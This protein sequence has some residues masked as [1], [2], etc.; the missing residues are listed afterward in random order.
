MFWGIL[1]VYLA[2]A[3]ATARTLMPWC[4]E[5]WFSGPAL[6]LLRWSTMGT[7]VLDAT[8]TWHGRNL[9]GIGQYTYWITPLYP[10]S[11]FLWFHVMPFGLFTVRLYSVLWGLV[12][13][14]AWWAL[15]RK[16]SG[17][18]GVALLAM[19][20]VA[21]DSAFLWGA[22]AGR[23]DIMCA[24]LGVAGLAVYVVLR[25]RH[26][27][28]AIALS[29]ASIAAA[30][31]AHPLALAWFAALVV[32]ML[33]FDGR[34]IRFRHVAWAAAPYLAAA[35]GWGIYIAR[36]PA[37][38]WAQFSGNAANR[39][40]TGSWL[41]LR[42]QTVERFLYTYGLG[43]DTHGFAHVRIVVLALYA[44]GAAGALA[45]RAIRNHK[46]YRALLL[47]WLASSAT[48]VLVDPDAQRFYMPHFSMPLAVLLA[49]WIWTSWHARAQEMKVPRWALAGMA[50]ALVAVQLSTTLWH[51][52]QDLYRHDYLASTG[53][54]KPRVHPGD[55]VFGSAE[56]AFEL[57]WDGTVVDDY[58]LGYR[59][60][61][62]AAFIVLDRNRYQEWIPALKDSEPDAYQ[63]IHGML[64]RDYRLVQQDAEY[65]VYQRVLH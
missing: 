62:Q 37:L 2:L 50:A 19:A 16:L 25:E 64:A 57:G 60:G 52:R 15:V 8:A 21:V 28:A 46:G 38:W 58:R 3:V 7:P 10:F 32:L 20:F 23:M 36:N 44:L 4:D 9:T 43:P 33:Y 35:A 49:V 41:W 18:E 59:T 27:T 30:A 54:L 39:L 42:K 12:A 31:L 53:Y 61:R 22:G 24:A 6:H 11:E 26:F 14:V 29:H 56:L 51:I 55:V 17:E 47:V 63:Y 45:S 65:E 13:L 1:V 5:A 40:P 34:R 48:I